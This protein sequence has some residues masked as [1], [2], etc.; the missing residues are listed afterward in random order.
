MT[1]SNSDPVQSS[2]VTIGTDSDPKSSQSPDESP[3]VTGWLTWFLKACVD[4]IVQLGRLMWWIPTHIAATWK[5]RGES[6]GTARSPG[7]STSTR[8]AAS[9]S[10]VQRGLLLIGAVPMVFKSIYRDSDGLFGSD[11]FLPTMFSI[12]LV[13][14]VIG[15]AAVYT[16][17][18]ATSQSFSTLLFGDGIF[19][20]GMGVLVTVLLGELFS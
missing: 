7:R 20:G 4:S 19:I 15:Y 18:M 3:G 9:P 14:S 11:G 2:G 10:L 13:A 5:S 16:V 6:G 12:L 8:S 1:D 17:N